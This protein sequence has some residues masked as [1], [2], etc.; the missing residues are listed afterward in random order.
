[1]CAS[2]TYPT[3]ALTLFVR[4]VD[5]L[6]KRYVRPR[7]AIT[8][9]VDYRT[10]DYVIGS[11]MMESTCKQLVSQRLKGPGMQWSERGAVAMTALI[12]H[13]INGTWDRYWASRPLQRAA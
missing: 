5:E 8:D 1:M 4:F 3:L 13:R 2:A 10:A 6:P 12:A 9:Y 11:G 7:L